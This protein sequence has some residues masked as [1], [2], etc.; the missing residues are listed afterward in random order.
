MNIKTISLEGLD[1]IIGKMERLGGEELVGKGLLKTANAVQG[2]AK[3][4]AP[5]DTGD[6]RDSIKVS[7]VKDR[8]VEVFTNSDHAIFNE[9][10]TGTKGDPEVP[11][12]SKEKWTYFGTDGSFHT[13]HGM[14]PRPFMRPAAK[15]GE[16]LIEEIFDEV[17]REELNK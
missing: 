13:T 4:L 10:G 16:E 15:A 7:D 3:L 9:Y 14:A 6:L 1:V 17:Y 12:T 5:V 11:H 8:K 2:Q